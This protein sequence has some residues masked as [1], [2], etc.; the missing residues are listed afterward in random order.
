[1]K[2]LL[3]LL[4]FIPLIGISQNKKELISTVNRLKN[5][6]AN[7]QLQM[8]N[9]VYEKNKKINER[10]QRIKE[11]YSNELE[12]KKTN[13]SYKNEIEILKIKFEN[14]KILS[15]SLNEK[16]QLLYDSLNNNFSEFEFL[17]IE[18]NREESESFNIDYL[19][20]Y[21]IVLKIGN[22]IIDI[23]T[24]FGQGEGDNNSVY[25]STS[26]PSQIIYSLEK[27]N[28]DEVLVNQLLFFNGE[29]RTIWIKKYKRSQLKL[30][31]DWDLINCEG[32]CN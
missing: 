12:L 3:F 21:A 19:A 8:K 26:V 11:L 22:S 9:V 17:L 16:V 29:E 15:D 23:Y 30:K 24:E 7:L 10:S 31:D 2:N 6:S 27:T 32:D 28:I 18:L 25:I 14:Q 13:K 4:T 5:D 1:M 20:E